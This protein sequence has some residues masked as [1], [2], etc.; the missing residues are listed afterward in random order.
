MGKLIDLIDNMCLKKTEAQNLRL[1]NCCIVCEI[2]KDD[3]NALTCNHPQ[4][5]Y[6]ITECINRENELSGILE[7]SEIDSLSDLKNYLKTIEEFCDFI[8][9]ES[10]EDSKQK[11]KLIFQ[12]LDVENLQEMLDEIQS[13]I[14]KLE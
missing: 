10:L 2:P 14:K 6:E 4:C 8:G 12:A 5:I 9:E 11:I 3:L 1:D 7:D 13:V